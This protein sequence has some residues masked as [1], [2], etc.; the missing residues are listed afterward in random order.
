MLCCEL[1]KVFDGIIHLLETYNEAKKKGKTDVHI[2]WQRM[3]IS[4]IQHPGVSS[5][6]SCQS[7]SRLMSCMASFFPSAN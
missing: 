7:K 3:L 6:R 2:G 5:Q 4:S 1:S